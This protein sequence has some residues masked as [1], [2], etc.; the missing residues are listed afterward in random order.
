MVKK[1]TERE[2]YNEII[3][4]GTILSDDG[5]QRFKGLFLPK[6]AYVIFIKETKGYEI[7]LEIDI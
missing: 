4:T 2:D 5:N 7:L 3:L 1:E 6:D